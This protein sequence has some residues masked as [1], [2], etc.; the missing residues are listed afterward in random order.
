M[1]IDELF[2]HYGPLRYTFG[3]HSYRMLIEE[4]MH[5]VVLLEPGP[6]HDWSWVEQLADTLC[7]DFFFIKERLLWI[8]PGAP[9]SQNPYEMLEFMVYNDKVRCT[10]CHPLSQEEFAYIK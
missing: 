5:L 10:K 8:Q 9:D 6:V 7:E 4:S 2:G 3:K 1:R